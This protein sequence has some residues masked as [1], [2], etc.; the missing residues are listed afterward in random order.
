MVQNLP[1]EAGDPGSGP[2][3]GRCHTRSEPVLESLGA[4]HPRAT[5]AGAGRPR[6]ELCRQRGPRGEGL[7]A[8][9]RERGACGEGLG[10]AGRVPCPLQLEN[11]PRSDQDPTQPA[12]N[13]Q[14]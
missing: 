3:R 9:A 13:K 6:L 1:A 8:T 14:T 4:A 10:A 2:D 12:M 5:A 7:G 11:S